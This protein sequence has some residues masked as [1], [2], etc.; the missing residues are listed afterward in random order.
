MPRQ[1]VHV[2]M[3]YLNKYYNHT[4]EYEFFGSQTEAG[5]ITGISSSSIS[6]IVRQKIGHYIRTYNG[7]T[8]TFVRANST[9]K[10]KEQHLQRIKDY[11][12]HKSVIMIYLDR[13]YN[14][15]GKYEVFGSQAEAREVT[16]AQSNISAIVNQRLGNY[17][18]T[19]KNGKTVTFVRANATKEEINN[20]IKRIKDAKK[21]NESYPIP[22]LMLYLDEYYNPAG[23]YEFFGS[24]TEA[25]KITSINSSSISTIVRQKIG[26]YIRTY[27]GKTV[28]FVR[29]NAT[30]KEKEQHIQR[31][32]DYFL[33]KSVIMI[34]LDR[35]YNPAGKYEVFGSQ[36]EAGKITGIA[37]YTIYRIINQRISY[38]IRTYNGKTVTF[39]RANSTR[40]EKEQ[41]L[42][43][44]K[45]YFLHKS[46][47]MIY[48]DRN[49]NPT[50]EYKIF[51]SQT[52]AKEV[53]NITRSNISVLV[54]QSPGHYTAT[55]KNGK[56][57]TFVR[58]NATK[59]E[60]NN[61]IKRIK[62]AKQA[63]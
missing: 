55:H 38:C 25:G 44:I 16:G 51:G 33:H 35:R 6:E 3:L 34:Y 15:A 61:H 62:D 8:V 23:E 7:K 24:Q 10:E 11:F 49:Y 43:R 60:I 9:R 1:A 26:H 21:P 2:L 4:G 18:T 20:H 14:P 40:K 5:K 53:T 63:I 27:N 39:V 59:E 46:V 28:T 36:A 13:R 54:N 42:Q 48:L 47:I 30:E 52:E 32:K 31:I 56:T 17:T 45:D 57:V 19:H 22:V 12:L 41:H 58:A 37:K 50:G 29:A